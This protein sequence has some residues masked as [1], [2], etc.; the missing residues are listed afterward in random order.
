MGTTD[1][2]APQSPSSPQKPCTKKHHHHHHHHDHELP[3]KS[4]SIDSTQPY[5]DYIPVGCYGKRSS[6]FRVPVDAIS[7][8]VNTL[9]LTEPRLAPAIGQLTITILLGILNI[10]C[11]LYLPWFLIP[12]AW[13]FA[14]ITLSNFFVISHDCVH[15]TFTS[16]KMANRII[17]E[18]CML[19]LAQPFSAYKQRHLKQFKKQQILQN[20]HNGGTTSGK[21][22]D[23]TENTDNQ[24]TEAQNNDITNN[25]LSDSDLSDTDDEHYDPGLAEIPPKIHH[26]V[27][28]FR[29][30]YQP[31]TTLRTKKI[32][33]TITCYCIYISCYII[34]N[35]VFYWWYT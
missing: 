17:G 7:D 1:T 29:D 31:K 8:L 6:T 22:L 26:A 9:H 33:S 13:V 20:I 34:T 14:G 12:L 35:I 4:A 23:T 10:I 18:L 24:A 21:K 2:I 27:K 25:P 15:N 5:D 11:L 28:W 32:C 30:T 19:P 16:S 3:S